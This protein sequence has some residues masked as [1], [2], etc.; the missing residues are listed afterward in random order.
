MIM[1]MGMQCGD[2]D[3]DN[4]FLLGHI[5]THSDIYMNSW[6]YLVS[7]Y[8]VLRLDIFYQKQILNSK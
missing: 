6:W 4:I 7:T 5:Y 3:S 2:G 1:G 8:L